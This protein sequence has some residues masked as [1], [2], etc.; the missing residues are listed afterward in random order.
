[1]S[2]GKRCQTEHWHTTHSRD[3]PRTRVTDDAGADA[4]DGMLSRSESISRQRELFRKLVR[5]DRFGGYEYA[6][7]PAIIP[8]GGF[9][10][11][12]CTPLR[13]YIVSTTRRSDVVAAQGTMAMLWGA[14]RCTPLN[15][16]KHRLNTFKHRLNTFKH[17]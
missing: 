14:W 9:D 13:E 7:V 11:G 5:M 10:V 6:M 8:T 3:C 17:V 1:M 12:E 2:G 4:A 16:F 15:T